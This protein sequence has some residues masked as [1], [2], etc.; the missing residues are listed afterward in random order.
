MAWYGLQRLQP[1]PSQ[2]PAAQAWRLA[3]CLP[4]LSLQARLC[5]KQPRGVQ[6][7][8]GPV[9]GRRHGVH[10]GLAAFCAVQALQ[11]FAKQRQVGVQ[12][13]SACW[14]GARGGSQGGALALVGG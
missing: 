3:P 14:G 11:V 9:P 4:C 5:Q 8:G 10:Q 1:G 13:V 2:H 6:A 12:Q 7:G